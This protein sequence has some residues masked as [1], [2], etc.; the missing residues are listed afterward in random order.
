LSRSDFRGCRAVLVV[1]V[2]ATPQHIPSW[3]RLPIPAGVPPTAAPDRSARQAGTEYSAATVSQTR[4]RLNQLDARL[5]A[6]SKWHI[7]RTSCREGLFF[8]GGIRPMQPSLLLIA[9]QGL[10]LI[11]RLHS[12]V[13]SQHV[14]HQLT[15]NETGRRAALLGNR[16]Q[17]VGCL[18]RI[19]TTRRQ[20][21]IVRQARPTRKT[22]DLADPRGQRQAAVRRTAGDRRHHGRRLVTRLTL[23]DLPLHL[24][25]LL[26]PDRPLLQLA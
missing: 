21:P 8:P 3:I 25:D 16:A 18:P 1:S 11:P 26:V 7:R 12:P 13:T 2:A 5:R 19:A 24:P 20:T 6:E 15:K 9:F 4:G 17:P 10:P 22:L 23:P 14:P